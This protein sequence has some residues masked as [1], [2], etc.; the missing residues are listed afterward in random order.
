MKSADFRNATWQ[1]I[2]A[3][4]SGIRETVYRSMLLTGP[5]TTQEISE[6]LNISILTVRPRVTE[7]CQMGLARLADGQ[8]SRKEGRY[9]AVPI[10]EAEAAHNAARS[11]QIEMRLA[12]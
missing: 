1:E 12:V 6:R 10:M 2:Q 11:R 3:K 4:I 5:G 8:V 7:L 9:E